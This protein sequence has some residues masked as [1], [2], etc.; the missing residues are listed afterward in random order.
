MHRDGIHRADRQGECSHR[1]VRGL[2]CIIG[3]VLL[4]LL[5]GEPAFG[6]FMVNPMKVQ[7]PG[8]RPGKVFVTEIRLENLSQVDT[9]TVGLRLVDLTQGP[10]GRWRDIP[11]DAPVVEGPD[12][13][14]WVEFGDENDRM[15]VDLSKLRSC[16]SWLKLDAESTEVPPFGI[17]PIRLFITV[18]PGTRGYYFAAILAESAVRQTEIDGMTSLMILQYLIP[19]IIE[20]EGRPMRHEIELV[21]V[22]MTFRQQTEVLPAATMVTM[23]IE[24]KG[25]TYARLIPQCRISGLLG[26]HWR[27]IAD[28]Q[29]PDNGI[30]PGVNLE[31]KHDVG[32]PLASG[33][34]KVEGFLYI[35]N[36]R[37]GRITKEVE[38]EGD[39]RVTTS[40]AEVPLDLDPRNVMIDAMPNAMRSGRITVYNPS[41]ETVR[42]RA[43]L[44]LPDHMHNVANTA[45]NIPGEAY[46]CADWVTAQ[47]ETFSLQGYGRR[48]VT[49]LARMPA[50]VRLPCYFATLKLHA[51]YPNGQSAGVTKSPVCVT[52]RGVQGVTQINEYHMT[53]GETSPSRYWVTAQFV[54]QGDTYA[55]P[56]CRAALTT[57]EGL[58]QKR[59]PMESEAR[60]GLLLPL[61]ARSYA[62]VL[63]LSDVPTGPYRLTAE[64]RF[65]DDGQVQQQKGIEVIE[66]GGKKIIQLLTEEQL[67]PLQVD[68]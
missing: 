1:R 67:E 65:G 68:F 32:R 56:I 14:R 30:I 24:N 23:G 10:D 7:P 48:T 5:A 35:D 17:Q 44:V 36:R 41:G 9:E 52:A 58:V 59:F 34:Y 37:G 2:A 42:V 39:P 51:T 31:L 61:E 21:D 11:P 25:G 26:G 33:K 47:P 43:E 29:F 60:Q 62:G 57:E 18:P 38:Y 55:Q 46:G 49:L 13:A 63:D 15:R 16:Q 27:R 19:V 12:G 4:A 6:Q 45:R 40:L 20:V 22:G 50:D 8:I 66:E 54:N 53:L 64:L 28:V 3:T